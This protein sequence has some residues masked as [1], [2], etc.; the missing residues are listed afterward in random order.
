L[1]TSS[2]QPLSQTQQ[3]KLAKS[4]DNHCSNNFKQLVDIHL[5]YYG[6]DNQ[7]HQGELIVNKTIAIET[8]AIFKD[9][10]AAKYHI[11]QIRPYS[12][13][14]NASFAEQNATVGYYCADLPLPSSDLKAHAN[15]TAIDI[16]PAMNP[17]VSNQ[18]AWPKTA[19]KYMDRADLPGVIR[20]GHKTYNIFMKHGWKWSGNDTAPNY[21]HFYK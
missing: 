14:P 4:Q 2:I 1:F 7:A 16:N 12:D 21:M 6:M 15:G 8:V 10:Y 18:N 19:A 13:F 3:T 17:Y 9:L 5:S 20:A 11:Q